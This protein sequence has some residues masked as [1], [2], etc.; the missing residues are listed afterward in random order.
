M[1]NFSFGGENGLKAET[2]NET[3]EV[4]VASAVSVSLIT[5]ALAGAYAIVNKAGDN[6]L[7][8]SSS[9]LN[10]FTE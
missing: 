7:E 4:I 5:L 10:K 2:D 1:F 3:A 6:L 8:S 9:V